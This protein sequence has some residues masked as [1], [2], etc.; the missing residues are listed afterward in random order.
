MSAD[1]NFAASGAPSIAPGAAAITARCA[2]SAAH[3]A[4]ELVAETGSTN[5]DLLARC[6]TLPG[7]T[8]LI[9]GQ[10]T[11]G[12]GRAGRSWLSAPGA[13]LM[14]SLAWK[15]KGPLQQLVGLPLA[16]G[17]A[18][19]EALAA[20]GAPVRL[21]WPND[22][23]KDGDK[24]AGILV[25][26]QAAEQGVWAVVG[27]GINLLMPDALE[28]AIGRPVAALPWLA[29]MPREDLMAALLNRLAATLAEFDDT[30]FAAF[31]ERWNR[32]HAHQGLAVAIV[33]RGQVLQRG[34]ALGVDALGRLLLDG[35]DGRVAVISGDV[36]L[37]P[38]TR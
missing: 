12:R 24:L 28:N 21:K 11:A 5:A 30:G 16:V 32:L 10:Q 36:S 9:A 26:T 33:D 13:T 27:V 34:V 35:A 18:L 37:R 4:I 38:A 6:A 3:V 14:F 19:A 22:L 8:L 1:W 15:F 2:A 31:S 25:E 20:L 17:V 29:Q 23:L 7:P